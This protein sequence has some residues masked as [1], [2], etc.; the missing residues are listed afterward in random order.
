VPTSPAQRAG[1]VIA[2]VCI[3]CAIVVTHQL[4]PFF[5]IAA[6]GLLALG[7]RVRLSGLPIVMAILVFAWIS[8]GTQAFWSGHL[9]A[10]TGEFGRI[11]ENVKAGLVDHLHGSSDRLLVQQMRMTLTAAVWALA[12]VGFFRRLRIG[13]PDWPIVM[14]AAAPFPVIALQGYGGEILLRIAY[15]ALPF[16]AYLG[17][18][19]LYPS[20]LADGHRRI[21]TAGLVGGLSIALAMAFLL[22]R[23]GNERFESFVPGELD[24]VRYVYD[25]APP[26]ARL[27]AVSPSLPWQYRDV[28]RYDYIAATEATTDDIGQVDTYRD[29]LDEHGTGPAYLILTRAQWAEVELT[30]GYSWQVAANL[31]QQ[32]KASDEFRLVYEN[33]AATVFAWTSPPEAE[34]S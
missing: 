27:V 9:A 5:L 18:L 25:H 22:A 33:P 16:M 29:L 32:L 14:L 34:T 12:G 28:E 8:Y 31:T 23:Y 30:L 10:I 7:R 15:F 17:A 6:T 19:A 11:G 20:T 13:R 2:I 26:G 3:Y 24:A 21:R 1:L 4:T